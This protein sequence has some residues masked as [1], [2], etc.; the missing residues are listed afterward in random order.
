MITSEPGFY[1]TG[2]TLPR[3]AASYVERQADRELY[4]ALLRGEYC[5]VLTARQMG[6]SSLM[7]H[8][9]ARL[10][11]EGVAVVIL[12]LTSLGRNLTVEQ[13][14]DG[15][16]ARIGQQLNLEDELEEYWSGHERQSPLQRWMGAL[17]EVVLCRCARQ[18]V[19][20][21]DEIDAVH[22]LPFSTDEFFAAIRECHNRR[23]Q[24]PQ[25]ARLTFCL[26]GVATPSDLI[27]D[28]RTTPFNI[29]RRI[30]LIDFSPGEAAPLARGLGVGTQAGERLLQPVLSWTGGHPYLTQRLCQAVA[31]TATETRDRPSVDQL[32]EELFLSPRARAK[33]DN[34]LFVRD[35]LLRSDVDRAALLDLY[36]RVRS[37][38][39]VPDD[40]ASELVSRLHLS[41]VVRSVDGRLQVRN[42]IY[43]R[44]FDRKWI[45]AHMPDAEL[46]RQKAAYRRGLVRATAVS[47]AVLSVVAGLA[48]TAMDQAHRASE[49]QKLLR[50]H[51]YAAQMNLAQ[52]VWSG[53]DLTG[54]RELLEAQQ[55]RSGQEDLRGFEWRYLWRLC[56]QSE[57]LF[58]VPG[59]GLVAFSPNGRIMATGGMETV[60][61]WD[62]RTRRAL[63]TL[64][65]H[66]L[67]SVAFSPDSKLLAL[68][69]VGL[70]RNAP[71]TVKLIDVATQR[72]VADLKGHS[73]PIGYV[74]FSPDGRSVAVSDGPS[75]V[76][77]PPLSMSVVTVWD[78]ASRRKRVT[79]KDR[80]RMFS[81]TFSPDGKTLAT[82]GADGIVKLWDNVSGRKM[83]ELKGHADQVFS[84]AFSP[85]GRILASGGK[86]WTARLWDVATRRQIATLQGH[87]MELSSVA[88]SPD[89]KILA[90]GS[91]DKMVKLWDVVGKRELKTLVGHG[92]MVNMVACSP[93]G[94][95]V[96]SASDDGTVKLW[97]AIR[98]PEGDILTTQ[99]SEAGVVAFSPDGKTLAIDAGVVKL[100][101]R[102]TGRERVISRLRNLTS[103]PMAFSS[104]LK[105]LAV[106][107]ESGA[108]ELWEITPPQRLAVLEG[109]RVNP[110]LAFSPDGKI[111]A[112][113]NWDGSPRPQAV[114]LWDIATRRVTKTSRPRDGGTRC[115]AFSPD[116]K[117]LA[118]S[119]DDPTVR[120]WDVA[121]RREVATFTG[122]GRFVNAVAFSR[123][124]SILASGSSDHTVKLWNC[125][126]HREV[127]TLKGHGSVVL[128]VG[129]SPDGK[130]L[131][132]GGL[133]GAVRL[134]SVATGQ[135]VGSLAGHRG[136]V[137]TI[138]FSPD[139]DLLATGSNDNTVRLW[140]AA[141]FAET[142]S[143]TGASLG[144]R[145]SEQ[146]SCSQ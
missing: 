43:E 13:W 121:A 28:T 32:C 82:A 42:R 62:V 14:Y 80:G 79:M 52:Q 76:D 110:A 66:L 86:D 6:K 72:A 8:T 19:I 37:G 123:D 115:V 69:S 89:G 141:S 73:G 93:D 78:V 7:V 4:E 113:G 106:P 83:G 144:R 53:G 65:T 5:Y 9:A 85:D 95:L 31:S 81:V 130:T 105:T 22:G 58:S 60:M 140:R 134:W 111:L 20:C 75:W 25:F 34:L 33:D 48:L 135:E 98:K 2:G 24:D 15:L 139:G 142:D 112:V 99:P 127:A 64:K 100:W 30:E 131:A 109:A 90:T 97:D 136:W 44:V 122:H 70:G 129:F 50:R 47:T 119:G 35:R 12:D 26:L 137:R 92:Q 45:T 71:H 96:A 39:R 116:G 29:G 17:Q 124:G 63:A 102:S 67:M 107:G 108:I 103:R 101:D 88:F 84:V 23:S 143:P 59:G 87:R 57:P 104:N 128:A 120:L 38:R 61:L 68:N 10:Q 55:P 94:R 27:Q 74:A 145:S 117:L 91:H 46:R 132:S 11:R 51:L 54:A 3:D 146:R 126:T 77:D 41:G 18:I 40:D 138:A 118:W 133:D 21:I 49:G 36:G 56:H 16:L 125:L 1:I 114:W